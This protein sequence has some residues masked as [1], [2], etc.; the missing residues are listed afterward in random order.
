MGLV[1]FFGSNVS[2]IEIKDAHLFLKNNGERP[3]LFLDYNYK[4]G[5]V[6]GYFGLAVP[7]VFRYMTSELSSV[8][9]AA[10]AFPLSAFTMH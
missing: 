6:R 1:I 5:I 4:P 3:C 9:S 10:R 8:E 2:Q 7:N